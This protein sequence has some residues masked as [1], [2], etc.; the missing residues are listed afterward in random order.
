MKRLL[1]K[2]NTGVDVSELQSALN[3]HIRSPA[4]PLKPDGI[5]GPLTDTRLREFQRLAK[6]N[7]DGIVGPIT[8]AD[9]Y[10]AIRGTIEAILTPYQ[11]ETPKSL[12]SN[13][14]SI[15]NQAHHFTPGLSQIH[16]VTSSFR[17]PSQGASQ[18][19]SAKSGGFTIESK[20]RFNPLA[21]PKEGDHPLRLTFSALLPWPILLPKPLKLDIT[22]TTI[23]NNLGKFQLDGKIKMP[24]NL[25]KSK[26]FVLKPYFFLGAGVN[27]NHFKGFSLGGGA[28]FKLKL[29]ENIGDSGVNLSLEADGGTKYKWDSKTGESVLKGFLEG[30]VVLERKF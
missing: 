10:R 22:T 30:G 14:P 20:F 18:T 26:H 17:P 4:K 11:T 16:P 15:P 13:Q 23:P 27:Q 1:S 8:T 28:A 12:L 29:F 7:V 19:H 24:F 3:F 21:K 2:G 9:I 25:I 5:F 6:I